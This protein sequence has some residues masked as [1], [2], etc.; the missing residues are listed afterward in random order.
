VQQLSVGDIFSCSGGDVYKRVCRDIDDDGCLEWDGEAEIFKDCIAPEVCIE[1]SWICE[2][3][4]TGTEE[5]PFL[6]DNLVVAVKFASQGFG[7]YDDD[8]NEWVERPTISINGAEVGE[9]IG[10]GDIFENDSL[11]LVEGKNVVELYSNWGDA[12]ACGE[13]PYADAVLAV[14]KIDDNENYIIQ[15]DESWQGLTYDEEAAEAIWKSSP[16]QFY[17]EDGG[18]CYMGEPSEDS[19]YEHI[20]FLWT[21]SEACINS[22]PCVSNCCFIKVKKEFWVHLD[23]TCDDECSS[24]FYYCYGDNVYKK[25]CGNFDSD[26]CLEYSSSMPSDTCDPATEIC[27]DGRCVPNSCTPDCQW[28]DVCDES[29]EDTGCGGICTR[30][31]DGDSCGGANICS[32]GVCCTPACQW[33]DV[34]D[35]FA[36]NGC[37]GTCTR[38]TDG[39][40]CGDGNICSDGICACVPNCPP[41]SCGDS[42]CPGVS[43]GGC[44][45]G[46]ECV[47]GYCVE[48]TAELSLIFS[49]VIYDFINNNE[50]IYTHTR[51]FEET[52]GVGVTLTRGELHYQSG[53]YDSATVSYRIEEDDNL[54]HTNK[55]FHTTRNSETFTLKYWGTD[56]NGNP[57][58]VEQVM[59]VAGSNHEP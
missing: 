27:S 1:G 39:D 26:S 56:D 58:Y 25:T 22:K 35:E 3:G 19:N 40:S 57:I 18:G 48:K 15:T 30:E 52:N 14:L 5:N 36:S 33:W 41:G 42:N 32:N 51:R 55:Q 29:A 9:T 16:Y 38:D 34:C 8:D 50:H 11:E 44:D 2:G 24:D 28:S 59:T 20:N 23:E 31:T 37:G 6:V 43:C 10:Y 12:D 45:A 7:V 21:E 4:A 53:G 47:N 49:D 17:R 46:Y 13:S 54:I